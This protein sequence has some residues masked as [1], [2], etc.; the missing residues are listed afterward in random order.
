MSLA[1]CRCLQ[2]PPF[3]GFYDQAGP[4]GSAGGEGSF[5]KQPAQSQVLS[6][7]EHESSHVIPCIY[8]FISNCCS[9]W[10]GFFFGDGTVGSLFGGIGASIP[11][12]TQA[13][14]VTS[15]DDIVQGSMGSMGPET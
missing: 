1:V 15:R 3:P 8:W 9:Y 7:N 4:D 13:K 6:L 10:K 12:G 5:E 14:K 2:D 11:R